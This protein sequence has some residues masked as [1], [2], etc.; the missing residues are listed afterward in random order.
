M[1]FVEA[2]KELEK[3]VGNSLIIACP[4]IAKHEFIKTLSNNLERKILNVIDVN[5]EE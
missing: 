5:M 4:G 2:A 1:L 3:N